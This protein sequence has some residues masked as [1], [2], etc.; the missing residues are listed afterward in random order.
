[1]IGAEK[2]V[3]EIVQS[4][5]VRGDFVVLQVPSL[6]KTMGTTGTILKSDEQLA[7]ERSE[8]TSRNKLYEVIAVGHLVTDFRVGDKCFVMPYVITAFIDQE[9]D[10]SLVYCREDDI[11][12]SIQ[13]NNF[14]FKVPV[15]IHYQINK[16]EA[17]ALN[18]GDDFL[19][20]D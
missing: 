3:K 19:A 2:T 7:R 14:E 10:R 20:I 12:G 9:A 15:P 13:R 1:M 4:L 11:L 5:K 6:S 18:Q 16:K 17:Q 8:L